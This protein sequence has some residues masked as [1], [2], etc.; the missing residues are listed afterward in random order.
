M[1]RGVEISGFCLRP[2]L[3]ADD[4]QKYSDIQNCSE[5]SLLTNSAHIISVYYRNYC[6]FSND[7]SRL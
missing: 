4:M 1:G 5:Y 6:T 7:I 3:L 2:T